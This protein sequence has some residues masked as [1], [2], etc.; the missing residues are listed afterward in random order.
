MAR[1]LY[2]VTAGSDDP[3]RAALPFNFALGA[4]EAGHQ[5]EIFL[6]GEG[7]YLLKEDV[8]GSVVPAGADLRVR[9]LLCGAWADRRRSQ[10]VQRPV[11]QPEDLR[12]EGGG[13]RQ[14]RL[15]VA[16]LLSSHERD[17]AKRQAVVHEDLEPL[18]RAAR[19]EHALRHDGDRR[20][21]PG[22]D[23]V[24]LGGRLDRDHGTV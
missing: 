13:G 1:I 24:E 22:D 15:A 2:V 10:V 11:H 4:L 23:A 20:D 9:P 19:G 18:A 5:P 7:V 16:G 6:T 12:R 17:R 8:A 3:I 14:S 21:G